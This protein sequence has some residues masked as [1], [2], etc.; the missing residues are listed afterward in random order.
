[1]GGAS[2]NDPQ[3]TTEGPYISDHCYTAAEKEVPASHTQSINE[4]W[5]H[6][7]TLDPPLVKDPRYAKGGRGGGSEIVNWH[8]FDSCKLMLVNSS[9]HKTL[10]LLIGQGSAFDLK[11]SPSDSSGSW[12]RI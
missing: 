3:P 9:T 5:F 12:L 1:M 4:A 8:S 11:K 7:P 10:F 6:L 2:K